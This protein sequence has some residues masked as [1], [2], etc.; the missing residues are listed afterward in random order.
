MKKKFPH[1]TRFFPVALLARCGKLTLWA[2]L[3]LLFIINV[4]AGNLLPVPVGVDRFRVIMD[5]HSIPAHLD[6]ARAL[7]DQGNQAM[8]KNE[9]LLAQ[10]SL[11]QAGGRSDEILEADVLGA[12]EE[13]PIRLSDAYAYWQRVAIEKPDYRDCYI[14][15]AALAYQ[16]SNIEEAKSYLLYAKALDPNSSVAN[17]LLSRL[18]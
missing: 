3:I 17:E 7:W 16:R 11:R 8:A 4:F 5:Y 18:P 1:F 15:L 2:F 10:S 6:L 9:L 13:E 12:W 14:L